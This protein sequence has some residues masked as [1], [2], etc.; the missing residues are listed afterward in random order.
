MV[1]PARR[2]PRWTIS[3]TPCSFF[4][5]FYFE[6]FLDLFYLNP[7]LDLEF[8]FS[9]KIKCS[10]TKSVPKMLLFLKII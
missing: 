1:L 5:N 10:G 2:L 6:A 4:S 8:F 9:S 7:F 3:L